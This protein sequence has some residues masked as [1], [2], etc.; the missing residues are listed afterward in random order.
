MPSFD[1]PS[2]PATHPDI[3]PFPPPQTFDILPDIYALISRLQPLQASQPTNDSQPAIEP[4]ALKDLPAAAVPIKQK[5]QRARVAVQS[6][7]D[8]DRKVEQ[9]EAEIKMLKTRI[10]MLQSRVDHLGDRA[11]EGLER[12][13]RE[14]EDTVM[15]GVEENGGKG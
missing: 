2:G 4:L 15:Q 5:I 9:Q 14:N 12:L 6:L 13:K 8:V 3:P 11:A 10:A 1:P 7:P